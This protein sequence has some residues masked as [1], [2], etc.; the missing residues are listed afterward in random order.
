MEWLLIL[1]SCWLIYQA[2]K[3]GKRTGSRKGFG[4]GRARTRKESRRPAR[5][6][7]G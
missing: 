1:G 3:A 2:Y 6:F 5:Q 4:A 7:F